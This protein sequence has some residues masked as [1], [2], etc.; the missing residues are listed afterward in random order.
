MSDMTPDELKKVT[1]IVAIRHGLETLCKDCAAG[2]D[3]LKQGRT[4]CQ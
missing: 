1:A 4:L 3:N 2:E